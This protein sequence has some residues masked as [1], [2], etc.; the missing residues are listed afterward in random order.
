VI[1][2]EVTYKTGQMSLRAIT[3]VSTFSKP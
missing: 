1:S 2:P 3:A